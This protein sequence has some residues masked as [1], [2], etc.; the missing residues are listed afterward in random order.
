MQTAWGGITATP[1]GL[2]V[3]RKMLA[4][5]SEGMLHHGGATAAAADQPKA[6]CPFAT[7]K[8]AGLL[9]GLGRR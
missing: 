1:S 3:G 2:V 7:L 6:K 8:D 5:R 9:R 4:A